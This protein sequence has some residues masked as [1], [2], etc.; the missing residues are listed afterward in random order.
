MLS[1]SNLSYQV[2]SNFLLDNVSVG[3]EPGKINLIIGPNGAGK[4][5]LVKA[6]SNNL[7]GYQG[8]VLYNRRNVMDYSLKDLARIRAVLSQSIDISFPLTVSDVVMMGRYPH[9]ESRPGSIDYTICREVMN[10]FE[11]ETF[12]ERNF[13][14]LSGG[15]RQRVHFA[16]VAAQIW[17]VQEEQSRFLMLDEPLTFL[18][19][20]YQYDLMQKLLQFTRQPG[21]VVVGV[22]HDL[23][24]ACRFGDHIV[25]MNRGKIVES[26]PPEN[27]I[28]TQNLKDVFK[29]DAVVRSLDGKTNI[30]M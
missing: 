18:D 12:A 27:V 16:R 22:I 10:F 20:Y 23:N 13:M 17:Q 28:T 8:N 9:F 15:E 2:G 4:S 24:L 6:L 21:V 29:I 7:S 5:T 30:W 25:L 26:G 14:T 1:A 3:F 19:I 11:V